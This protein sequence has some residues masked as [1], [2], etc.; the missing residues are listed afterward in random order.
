MIKSSS[1]KQLSC[2]EAVLK[3]NI[4]FYVLNG[5]FFTMMMNLFKPFTAKFL[6]RIGGTDF[7]ISLLNALPGLVAVFATIPGILLI[8]K[9][10]NKKRTISKFFFSSRLFVLLFAIV[11]FLPKLY[12]P[13]IFVILI[14]LRQ[15][16]ES[17]SL[18]SLQSFTGDIFPERKRATAIASRNMFS[19]AAQLITVISVDYILKHFGKSDSIILNIY[20]IFFIV[21]FILGLIEI[22][23]FTKLKENKSNSNLTYSPN[24]TSLLF[25][26]I[27]EPIKIIYKTL[28]NKQ[29]RIFVMCSLLYHFG[30]QMGWPLF[31]TYQIKYLGADEHW[32]AIISIIS[33]IVMFFCYKFWNI[34]IDK[35]GNPPVMAVTTLGMA[36]T[37]L[38]YAFSPNLKILAAVTVITGFFTSGTVT[39]LLNSLLEVTPDKNR[40]FYV[41]VHVTLTSITLS[42]APIV[43]NA[44]HS[45]FNIYTAL[46][47]SSLFRFLGSIAFFI[48]NK[49]LK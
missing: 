45:Y 5:I 19:I 42:I 16:P 18:T 41:G 7:H 48:R 2:S 10:F 25:L 9:T 36:A 44:L 3:H 37:P 8:N 17:V 43:G 14:S 29:Y 22:F 46:Y 28:N 33:S 35:K 40:I 49:K 12:Q 15:Y 34:I 11:P 1:K 21:S 39:V 30:W 4:F 24:N 38:L 20:Q 31:S 13:I 47:I 32:L 27:I 26:Y 23:T 6:Y